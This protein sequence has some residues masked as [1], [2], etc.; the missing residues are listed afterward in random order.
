MAPSGMEQIRYM[1]LRKMKAQAGGSST[2]IATVLILNRDLYIVL[3]PPTHTHY[4]NVVPV[5][6]L[7]SCTASTGLKIGTIPT[8]IYRMMLV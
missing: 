7:T 2:V 4:I 5:E 1:C 8:A 3:T 6:L